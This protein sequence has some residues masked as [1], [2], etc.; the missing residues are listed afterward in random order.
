MDYK[1]SIIVPIYGAEKYIKFCIESLLAQTLKPLEILLIDDGSP[2]KCGDICDTFASNYEN[3]R[4][5]HLEKG[6]PSN[7]RNIGISHA[8]GKYIGFVDADDYAAPDMFATLYENAC[9]SLAD[10]VMCGYSIDNN[11]QRHELEMDYKQ[12][13]E[14]NEKIIN[15]L[16]VLYSKRNHNGLYS[17]CNKLF[18]ANLLR[19]YNLKFDTNLIRAEDA[20]FVFNAFKVASKVR[21]INKSLYNYRQVNTSTMHTVQK[22]RYERSKSFRIKLEKE[23]KYLELEMDYDEFYYEFLYESYVYCRLMLQQNNKATVEKMLEDPFFKNAC[24]YDKYLPI[25]LRIMCKLETMNC[26]IIIKILLKLWGKMILG[27]R[28]KS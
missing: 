18:N 20:W 8:R 13:Y 25:Q 3:I 27:K 19:K 11:G 28:E 9:R 22:D 26:T 5:F 4:A 7:A 2:D 6:G 12:E 14:G 15:E 10:I 17:V 1:V 23:F 16:L 24:Q 21:F